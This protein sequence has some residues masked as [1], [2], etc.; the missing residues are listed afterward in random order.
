LARPVFD[1]ATWIEII[2]DDGLHHG[3]IYNNPIVVG[4]KGCVEAVQTFHD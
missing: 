1:V 4:A 3:G 2:I